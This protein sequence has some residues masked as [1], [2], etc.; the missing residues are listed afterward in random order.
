MK[1]IKICL[2]F[3]CLLHF[4]AVGTPQDSGATFFMETEI[5]KPIKGFEGRYEISNLG[6]IKSLRWM[7][8]H[9]TGKMFLKRERLMSIRVGTAFN[10]YSNVMLTG[11]DGIQIGLFHHRIIA[12]AFI[13]NPDNKPFVNHLNGIKIDNRLENLEWCTRSENAIHSFT[14]GLQDNKGENHPKHKLTNNQVLSIRLRYSIGESSW[15]IFKSFNGSQSY[16][17]I[18]NIIAKRTW[19]H[20]S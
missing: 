9:H 3:L 11:L 19:A 12:E 2:C 13:P 5:W 18:K 7:Q 17:N 6:R 4:R 8:K 10:G 15:K 1:K 16:T 20:L 14:I